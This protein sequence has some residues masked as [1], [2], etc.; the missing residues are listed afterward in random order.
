MLETDHVE[1]LIAAAKAGCGIVQ[2]LSLSV[3][4]A[5]CQT[6]DIRA[7]SYPNSVEGAPGEISYCVVDPA[8]VV[9]LSCHQVTAEQLKENEQ[10][11]SDSRKAMLGQFL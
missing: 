6:V 11:L 2:L 4:G 8:D 5:I 9:T 7:F 1:S 3:A 10:Y